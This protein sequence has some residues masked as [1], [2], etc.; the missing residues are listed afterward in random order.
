M[1]ALWRGHSGQFRSSLAS[2]LVS[3]W[4][5]SEL[6]RFENYNYACQHCVST[7]RLGTMATSSAHFLVKDNFR[8]LQKQRVKPFS[9]YTRRCMQIGKNQQARFLKIILVFKHLLTPFFSWF[10]KRKFDNN[11][12]K[13][14][15]RFFL[16]FKG[17]LTSCAFDQGL[18][19][20]GGLKTRSKSFAVW[21]DCAAHF[22]GLTSAREIWAPKMRWLKKT[23]FALHETGEKK[24]ALCWKK[25]KANRKKKKYAYNKT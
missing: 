7:K 12:A 14:R 9:A 22:S 17:V 10:F 4:Q 1:I 8:Y 13:C 24:K 18:R 3:A 5:L 21:Q 6:T 23:R 20:L 25:K 2:A 19:F 16:L 15:A 11:W